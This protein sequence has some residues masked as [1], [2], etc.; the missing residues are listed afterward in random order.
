MLQEETVDRRE[1]LVLRRAAAMPRD[2]RT[3]SPNLFC[4]RSIKN[5]SWFLYLGV[6]IY[7][8]QN[9]S[10]ILKVVAKIL[11][12]RTRTDS[13]ISSSEMYLTLVGTAVSTFA[14]QS[15][16]KQSD[17]YYKCWRGYGAL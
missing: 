7:A 8:L 6:T 14:E 2:T 13:Y 15:A 4:F 3:S 16:Y 9:P 11:N 10:F 17:P 1:S 12:T 5:A